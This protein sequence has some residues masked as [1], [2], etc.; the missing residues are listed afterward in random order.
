[1]FFISKCRE[2]HASPLLKAIQIF[3][4]ILI[5]IGIGLFFTQSRWLPNLTNYILKS[6]IEKN[7]FVHLETPQLNQL[8]QS[9]L[10]VKGE[11]KGNWFFEASFPVFLYDLD[12][13]IIARGI[14]TAKG[15]WMTTEFV[16][17]E[18]AGRKAALKVHGSIATQAGALPCRRSA[19]TGSSLPVRRTTMPSSSEALWWHW[20]TSRPLY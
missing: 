13:K 8:V 17:F 14:A 12:G 18:R 16:P 1:M 6:E 3:L 7:N 20:V 15:D 2:Y 5:V 11:A 9:P 4:L 19:G 10:I